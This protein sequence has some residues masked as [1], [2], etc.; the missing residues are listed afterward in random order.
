MSISK[1]REFTATVIRLAIVRLNTRIIEAQN[2]KD[3][4]YVEE[5]NRLIL[6]SALWAL[7]TNGCLNNCYQ[8]IWDFIYEMRKCCALIIK[9]NKKEWS[10]DE[11]WSQFNDDLQTLIAIQTHIILNNYEI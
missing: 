10:R 11:V 8:P 3:E 2:R 4:I 9:T 6:N 1:D 5:A 7:I